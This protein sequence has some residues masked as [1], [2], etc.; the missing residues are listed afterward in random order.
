MKEKKRKKNSK[1]GMFD[2]RQGV[3]MLGFFFP[4]TSLLICAQA[5]AKHFIFSD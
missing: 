1:G 5:T 4:N 3:G 2:M